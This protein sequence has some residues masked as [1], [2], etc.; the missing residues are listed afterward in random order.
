MIVSPT[1]PPPGLIRAEQGPLLYSASTALSQKHN[2][3]CYA[4][5]RPQAQLSELLSQS[6]SG[7]SNT[8]DER[9]TKEGVFSYNDI[10]DQS[11]VSLVDA[12]RENATGK[13]QERRDTRDEDGLY[14][15]GKYVER[16]FLVAS[17]VRHSKDSDNANEDQNKYTIAESLAELARLADTVGLLVTGQTHQQLD[18]PE[19][20]MYVGQGK[21]KE[22]Q[23]AILAKN[24]DTVIFDDELTPRQ[25]R[26]LSEV[27][28]SSVRVCDRT[29]LILDIFSQRAFTTEGK[30]QV[31]LAQSEYQLPRLTR[32]WTHLERQVGGR[33]K[34]MGEKQIEVDKRLLRKRMDQLRHQLKSVMTRRQQ[35]KQWR[36]KRGIPVAALVGYTNAGKST[37]LNKLTNANVFAED[38]LF[39]TLD[40]TT[41]KV[42]LP[43]GKQ[44]LLSDTVGFIQKLPT[45]LIAA[46]R[47]TLGEIRDAQLLVHVVDISHPNSLK[48]VS[49][50]NSVLNDLGIHELD[51]PIVQ[52][53]NK[54]D[55]CKNPNEL[56]TKAKNAKLPTVCVSGLTG[57]GIE[58]M[59]DMIMRVMEEQMVRT[60][61]LIPYTQGQIVPEVKADGVVYELQHTEEGYRIRCKLPMEL[62]CRL[63]KYMI[64]VPRN[65]FC[66]RVY[67]GD[68]I[69]L[70]DDDE[71]EEDEQIDKL[72]SKMEQV[73]LEDGYLS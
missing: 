69:E 29:A 12:M 44:I 67:R 13:C 61:L 57:E 17:K 63:E 18:A 42:K 60:E 1:K 4:S 65:L 7:L 53:W 30:L 49:A 54:I 47:A 27:F 2:L 35:H 73:Q 11:V 25:L 16:V 31:E 34:G 32:M 43:T 68:I 21:L 41:R 62:A 52:V 46:F 24:V 36:Q 72:F 37:L 38:K 71:N 10:I 45:Q 51:I 50:V 40:P 26:N 5:S 3:L 48:Q 6:G 28:G 22:I 20:S 39:A 70:D 19:N 23:H 56:R 15:I 66:Q 33:V 58:D 8:H 9:Q 64:I 55:S 59:L 14:V